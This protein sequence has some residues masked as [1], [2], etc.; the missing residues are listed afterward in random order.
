M[1]FIIHRMFSSKFVCCSSLSALI[2]CLNSEWPPS[3]LSCAVSHNPL[4]AGAEAPFRPPQT[5]PLPAQSPHTKSNYIEWTP[6][7]P[8]FN[9][10][11]VK[12]LWEESLFWKQRIARW[13]GPGRLSTIVVA[14]AAEAGG[15]Q[16]SLLLLAD[17]R[18]KVNQISRVTSWHCV[19]KTDVD[20]GMNGEAQQW[21]NVF[22]GSG[23]G[24]PNRMVRHHLMTT[25]VLRDIMVPRMWVLNHIWRMLSGLRFMSNW[26]SFHIIS[27]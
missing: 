8:S 9:K 21:H 14:V 7:W 4:I 13:M 25:D 17:Y 2:D 1:V 5:L 20:W 23:Y 18:G 10:Y 27:L 11:F 24:K 6:N 3:L 22:G 16:W 15:S 12:L 19:M 26:H